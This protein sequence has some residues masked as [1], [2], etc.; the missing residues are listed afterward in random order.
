[1][2]GAGSCG[3]RGGLRGGPDCACLSRCRPSRLGCSAASLVDGHHSNRTPPSVR[4]G[5]FLCVS[6]F[7]QGCALPSLLSQTDWAAK[8][9]GKQAGKQA[10]RPPWAQ[11]QR[12]K[13]ANKRTQ[14][15]TTPTSLQIGNPG[16][17]TRT[18]TATALTL[19]ILLLVFSPIASLLPPA[20][21][22]HQLSL[23]SFIGALALSPA[24]S[25]ILS[26]LNPVAATFAIYCTTS[27]QRAASQGALRT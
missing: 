23:L 27:S 17:T 1:M 2:M 6:S 19:H 5:L 11:R 7:G 13:R 26:A 14:Q 22:T 15:V 12:P 16:A 9:V 4:R 10:S 3:L 8:S 20:L 18:A 21:L 24:C 25:C